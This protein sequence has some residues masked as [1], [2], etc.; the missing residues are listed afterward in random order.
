MSLAT[1]KPCFS[2]TLS[3]V[4]IGKTMYVLHRGGMQSFVPAAGK[5]EQNMGSLLE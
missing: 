4:S 1:V 2:P 3:H 5:P